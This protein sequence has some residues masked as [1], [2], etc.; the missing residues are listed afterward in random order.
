[1][2]LYLI[3]RAPES[4]NIEVMMSVKAESNGKE[5]KGKEEVSVAKKHTKFWKLP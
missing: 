3:K 5:T 1:L 4:L 2:F